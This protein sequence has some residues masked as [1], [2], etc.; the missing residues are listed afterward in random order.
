MGK[1]T[2]EPGKRMVRI[3]TTIPAE[4]KRLLDGAIEARGL[5]RSEAVAQAVAEY[6]RRLV[7]EDTE[8]AFLLGSKIDRRADEVKGMTREAQTRADMVLEALRYQFPNLG[9]VSNDELKRRA[10]NSRRLEG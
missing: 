10:L 4:M 5:T 2:A 3:T 6:V 8:R 1:N 7:E 9:N